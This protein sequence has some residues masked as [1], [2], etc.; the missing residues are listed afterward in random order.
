MAYQDHLSRQIELLGMVLRRLLAAALGQGDP[1]Q[2]R[3]STAE[4]TQALDEAFGLS[5]G[6]LIDLSLEEL[7]SAVT[8]HAAGNEANLD[9]LADLLMAWAQTHPERAAHHNR[10]ALALLEHIKATSS[11]FDLE[12]YG[13][14]A[15]LKAML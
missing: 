15:R 2:A 11:T 14:V 10:Q 7:L 8:S 1:E 6:S 13:K 5:K 4:A 9:L 3:L 12:R